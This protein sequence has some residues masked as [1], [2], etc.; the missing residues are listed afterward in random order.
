MTL[1]K[2]A[3]RAALRRVGVSAHRWPPH[4]FDAM[5]DALALLR[6]AGYRPRVVIDAGANEGAWATIAHSIF[7]EATFHLVEPQPGCRAALDALVQQFPAFAVHP[8]A[9]TRPDVP[10]VRLIGSG[11]DGRGTGAWVAGAGERDPGEIEC[12]AT[13]LDALFADRIEPRDR[14]LLKLDLEGHEAPALAGGQRLL[15][16]VEVALVEVRFYEIEDHDRPLFGDLLEVMRARGFALYDFAALAGRP[17]DLRLRT[18]DAIFVRR[19]SPLAA[20]RAWQ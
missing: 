8:I 9:V 18:G 7:P 15:D 16:V 10:R 13:T 19:D 11:P 12:A 1:W 4:R 5:P 17:R 20:D 14:A 6:R 2:R 3:A